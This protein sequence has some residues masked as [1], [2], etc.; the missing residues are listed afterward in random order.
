MVIYRLL[1]N[2]QVYL[3]K[4][5]RYAAPPTGKHRWD[6]PQPP[7]PEK[8]IQNGSYGPQCIQSYLPNN[9]P[10]SMIFKA[11]LSNT[12]GLSGLLGN[13]PTQSEGNTIPYVKRYCA[14]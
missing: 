9:S 5:I 8:G 4:N 10:A 7:E 6:N 2:L 3:F 12:A 13:G 14:L 1:I 11:P